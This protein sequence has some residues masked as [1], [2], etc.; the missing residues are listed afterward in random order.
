MDC[1]VEDLYSHGKEGL[2]RFGVCEL[3]LKATVFYG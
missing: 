2:L 3:L 1:F